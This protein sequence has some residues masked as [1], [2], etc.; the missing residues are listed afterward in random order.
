MDVAL[1]FKYFLMIL[2]KFLYLYLQR[3]A[4]YQPGRF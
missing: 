4:V 2:F 3:T 1:Y